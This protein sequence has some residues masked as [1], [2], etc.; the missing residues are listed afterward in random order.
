MAVQTIYLTNPSQWTNPVEYTG[1]N[2]K[3]MPNTG[4]AVFVG[5]VHKDANGNGGDLTVCEEGNNITHP[6]PIGIKTDGRYYK[7]PCSQGGQNEQ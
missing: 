1:V 6:Q 3:I 7:G 4:T 5:H 2:V